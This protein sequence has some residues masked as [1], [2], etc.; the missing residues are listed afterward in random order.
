[1][2]QG[3]K[4][5]LQAQDVNVKQT[6]EGVAKSS[7]RMQQVMTATSKSSGQ[8]ANSLTDFSRVIQ[9]APY[10]IIGVSNNITQLAEGFGRLKTQTGS[11]KAALSAMVGSLAGGG[12]LGLA[13]S[14]ITT[15][16]SFAT[17][18]L[19]AWTRGF[20]SNKKEVQSAKEAL[21]EFVEG[22]GDVSRARVEG[23]QNA[24][25]EIVSLQLLY[26]ASQDHSKSLDDRKKAVDA[27]QQQY[28]KYFA[29]LSDEAILA[30]KGQKAYEN[31]AEAII[32]TSKARAAQDL[33]VEL[34][35]QVLALDEQAAQ[36]A[37]KAMKAR[38]L[39]DSA[40]DAARRQ[41]ATVV[42]PGAGGGVV[43]QGATAAVVSTKQLTQAG[44]EL[45]KVLATRA[46]LQQ[47]INRLGVEA[48]S[49]VDALVSASGA[50]PKAV[51]AVKD[52]IKDGFKLSPLEV[53][54]SLIP[55]IDRFEYDGSQFLNTMRELSERNAGPKIPINISWE[56]TAEML[57]NTDAAEFKKVGSRIG[58][59]IGE[60]FN[61][62]FGEQF[63]KSLL[64]FTATGKSTE[65]IEEFKSSLQAI[66]VVSVDMLNGIANSFGA[67]F[68]ALAKGG[69]AMQA[70]G[71]SLMQTIAG[72][73]SKLIQAAA[74]AAILSV[75]SGGAAG[76]GASFMGAF[77]GI[78][79]GGK[80]P[81]LAKGGIVPPGY[82]NDTYPAML[83]SNEAVFPL[84]RLKEFIGNSSGGNV[85]VFGELRARGSDLVAVLSREQRSQKRRF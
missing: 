10:G 5:L 82:A 26:K 83:S 60:G 15:A 55:K 67:F 59:Q 57:R 58:G 28:P 74:L 23:A 2:D 40:G 53:D 8:A 42:T 22:L 13:I 66:S 34:Q 72:I 9:D 69:N 31:L 7:L 45:N 54:F 75:I 51:A 19:G 16:L 47:R 61:T 29:N 43:T 39:R 49:D 1:M 77:K 21:S 18:G 79:G 80:I 41:G 4:I 12:G 71:Q 27:L 64:K 6:F 48:I 44:E 78:L 17:V 25:K 46:G 38:A 65:Q 14:V 50:A 35:K 85:G 20:S 68:D 76:G 33:I 73:I 11:T 32:K 52:K 30:G 81:G 84:D 70:F 36:A 37:Q 56:Q 62:V 3:L 63:Q 24:Q